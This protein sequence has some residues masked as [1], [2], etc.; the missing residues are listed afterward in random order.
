MA[1]RPPSR[2]GGEGRLRPTPRPNGVVALD[3]TIAA[4]GELDANGLCLQWRNHL[5][6][7]LPPICRVGFQEPSSAIGRR[8]CGVIGI[9]NGWRFAFSAD[10]LGELAVDRIDRE[11]NHLFANVIFAGALNFVFDPPALLE[12]LANECEWALV[13]AIAIS[14]LKNPSLLD[15]KTLLFCLIACAVGGSRGRSAQ[16]RKSPRGRRPACTSR[17]RSPGKESPPLPCRSWK[18]I[19][20]E[21]AAYLL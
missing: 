3:H 2:G 1:E 11:F 13:R 21:E 7:T 9:G 6:G 16:A 8:R 15:V 10:G 19:S 18:T 17:S 4:L 5:G 12:P 20:R 14:R